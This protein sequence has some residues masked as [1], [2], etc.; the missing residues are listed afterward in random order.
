MKPKYLFKGVSGLTIRDL[1]KEQIKA[2]DIDDR[3]IFTKKQIETMQKDS[4]INI[5][6]NKSQEIPHIEKELENVF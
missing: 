4:E 6:F 2:G 3:F 5:D 1:T